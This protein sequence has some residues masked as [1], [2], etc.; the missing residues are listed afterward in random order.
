MTVHIRENWCVIAAMQSAVNASRSCGRIRMSPLILF[1]Q[2]SF[3]GTTVPVT[4]SHGAFLRKFMKTGEH[5]SSRHKKRVWYSKPLSLGDPQQ[6]GE[7]NTHRLHILSKVFLDRITD[8]LTTGEISELIL[9][10][11]MEITRVRV[12][13]HFTGINVY[14]ICPSKDNISHL[15][16]VLTDNAWKIRHEL[17]QQRIL[18]KVP[19]LHFY[20]DKSQG[21]LY[22]EI[23]KCLAVADFGPDLCA[24]ED[25]SLS[26]KVLPLPDAVLQNDILGVD[27]DKIYKKVMQD[28]QRSKAAHCR[29]SNTDPTVATDWSPHA[30]ALRKQEI[31]KWAKM[32][33]Q[34][35][36]SAKS[37]K[38]L[39]DELLDY[40]MHYEN[41]DDIPFLEDE[42][43]IDEEENI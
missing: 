23:E 16:M 41:I 27:V 26:E 9:G 36:K 37:D 42:D 10:H 22:E 13:P 34:K 5:G 33:S 21:G 7:G 2:S 8:I 31:Q 17:S 38:I 12:L 15:E 3:F 1:P 29:V 39:N 4:K 30:F 40:N 32:Y 24:E 6:K 35:K 11:R 25:S 28:V 14:W 20:K 19:P 43:Y 18:G